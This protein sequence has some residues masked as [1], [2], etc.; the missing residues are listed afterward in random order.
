MLSWPLWIGAFVVLIVG[1]VANVFVARRVRCALERR[2][3]ERHRV[4]KATANG[5]LAVVFLLVTSLVGFFLLPVMLV[6]YEHLGVTWLAGTVVLWAISLGWLMQARV[7]GQPGIT[8]RGSVLEWSIGGTV[9]GRQ[10]VDPSQVSVEA[11]PGFPYANTLCVRFPRG[12]LVVV[13]SDS[14]GDSQNWDHVGMEL[15]GAEWERANR[16]LYTDAGAVALMEQVR[17]QLET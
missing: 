5:G 16:R 4:A 10:E 17:L 3:W 13:S 8:L 7:P 6:L 12:T 14:V 9:I 11:R 2:R 1:A 15:D